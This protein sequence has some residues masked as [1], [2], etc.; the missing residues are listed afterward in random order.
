MEGLIVDIANIDEII[1]IIKKSDNSKVAADR[2]C[3]RK[4]S[5]ST[6][7]PLLDKVADPNICKPEGLEE[8]FGLVDSEYKLSLVQA[9]AILELRLSR[10]TALETDKLNEEYEEIVKQIKELQEI[11]SN[12]ARLVE[13]VE[14][15]LIDC[16]LYT[17]PS[18]RDDR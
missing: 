5:A 8:G 10:L 18:P 4:W 3:E 16:L 1:E 6:I 12:K 17:S 11:L 13:V 7:K 9:K 2:L 14:E 15:E